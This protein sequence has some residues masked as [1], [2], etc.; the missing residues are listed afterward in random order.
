MML[1]TEFFFPR[2]KAF[3][4]KL[5]FIKTQIPTELFHFQHGKFLPSPTFSLSISVDFIYLIAF[6]ATRDF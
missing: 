5:S 2:K 3:L 6:V 4:L 1:S